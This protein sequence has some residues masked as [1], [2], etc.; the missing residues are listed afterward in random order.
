M[1]CILRLTHQGYSATMAFT[2]R[3]VTKVIYARSTQLNTEINPWC[4]TECVRVVCVCRFLKFKTRLN[5]FADILHR[6]RPGPKGD[7]TSHHPRGGCGSTKGSTAYCHRSPV[8]KPSGPHREHRSVRKRDSSCSQPVHSHEIWMFR[9]KCQTENSCI[10]PVQLLSIT[11]MPKTR[12]K[13]LI[14]QCWNEQLLC[15]CSTSYQTFSSV[16]CW[17][18]SDRTAGPC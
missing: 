5:L 8:P 3:N 1:S 15:D 10:S 11:L 9:I 6:R 16:Y 17:V 12:A 13:N 4:L 7:W 2:F 18:F 14:V